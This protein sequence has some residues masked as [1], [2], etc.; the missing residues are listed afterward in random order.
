MRAVLTEWP[1]VSAPM[2][3]VFTGD[4]RVAPRRA[5][6]FRMDGSAR[7]DPRG[8]RTRALSDVALVAGQTRD[9]RRILA[10]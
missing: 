8:D 10:G 3:E 2:A 7:L 1:L 6:Q 9:R 5:A 4:S